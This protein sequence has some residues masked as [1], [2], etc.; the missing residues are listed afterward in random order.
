MSPSSSALDVA[1]D[2][3][4]KLSSSALD[5]ADEYDDESVAISA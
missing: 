3:M 2:G 5:A 1:K 4:M